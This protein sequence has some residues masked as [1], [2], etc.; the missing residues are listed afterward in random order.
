METIIIDG[1]KMSD[2]DAAYDYLT[3]Q[4]GL[5][6]PWGRNLDALFDVL[7]GF[8]TEPT[9]LEVRHRRALEESAYGAALLKTLEDAAA[10]NPALQVACEEDGVR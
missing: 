7:T 8:L 2:R 3:G 6:E 10:E 9:R 5:P 1:S 4:L